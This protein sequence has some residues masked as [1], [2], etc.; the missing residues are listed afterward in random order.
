MD[1]LEIILVDLI[2]DELDK[3][4]FEEFKI[5]VLEVKSSHFFDNNS[6]DDIVFHQINSFQEIL[7]PIGT[8]NIF[9]SHLEIGYIIKD[10]MVV[11]SFD[12]DY[13]DITINFPENEL[14]A[15]DRSVQ[16]QRAYKLVEFLLRLRDK[17]NIAK[18]KIGFEPASDDD[19]CLVTI[20]E[21]V[22]DLERIIEKII[23]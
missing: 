1:N 21:E 20:E 4:V 3:M 2:K 16:K 9:L 13:G 11:F 10:V 6:K 12:K 18:V 8:G 19:T 23:R 5:N 17:Y 14:F 7:S 15:V 22:D